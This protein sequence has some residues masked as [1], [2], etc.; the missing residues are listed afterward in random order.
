MGNQGSILF[1]IKKTLF[2]LSTSEIVQ[3]AKV[4]HYAVYST[5]NGNAMHSKSVTG[6]LQSPNPRTTLSLRSCS[7]LES[8]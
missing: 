8:L 2:L 3:L 5:Y 6:R 1:S 7:Y 4:R